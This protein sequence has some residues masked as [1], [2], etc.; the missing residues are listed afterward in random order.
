MIWQ[1]LETLFLLE[2]QLYLQP[3]IHILWF[4]FYLH[5]RPSRFGIYPFHPLARINFSCEKKF[6]SRK[7]VGR[8]I[9]SNAGVSVHLPGQGCRGMGISPL[10]Q[11]C[12]TALE[13]ASQLQGPPLQQE[14]RAHP[15]QAR[16][17]LWLRGG[18]KQLS[19]ITQWED[20]ECVQL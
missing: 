12:L 11:G 10:Y 16:G 9:A 5:T 20:L 18:A 3:H 13:Q 1:A 6:C 17:L 15:G 14:P 7:K 8:K 2:W 19:N 4:I